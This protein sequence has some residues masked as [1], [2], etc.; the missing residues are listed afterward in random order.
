MDTWADRLR[1]TGPCC[2]HCGSTE[3]WLDN[4]GEGWLCRDATACEERRHG[5]QQ[6][7]LELGAP[8]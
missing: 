2:A 7:E 1:R 5:A 8:Q 3:G 4:Y 6:L